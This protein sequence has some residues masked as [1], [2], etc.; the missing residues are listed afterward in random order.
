MSVADAD[1]HFAKILVQ[2][3]M[4]VLQILFTPPSSQYCQSELGGSNIL[5]LHSMSGANMR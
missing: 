5:Q 1:Y 4:K 3:S 2:S